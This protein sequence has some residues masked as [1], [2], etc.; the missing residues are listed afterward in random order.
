MV[1]QTVENLPAIQD[2]LV[3]SLGWENPLEKYPHSSIIAW[4][5]PQTEEPGGPR[6]MGLK[7]LNMTE[8]LI[9]P[10]NFSWTICFGGLAP[11]KPSARTESLEKC[12][13]ILPEHC[14]PRQS[15]P[16]NWPSHLQ[17]KSQWAGSKHPA[18]ASQLVRT[19]LYPHLTP[20]RSQGQ[21]QL[22]HSGVNSECPPSPQV[23]CQ[24]NSCL[25]M[26]CFPFP[27]Q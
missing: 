7:Q 27:P 10:R 22:L 24:T 6:S 25:T 11:L 23:N 19:L 1:A 14:L 5:I 16:S 13:L 17:R 2:T 26:R 21:S 3:P 15:I 18:W 20:L 8:Q 4:R 12:F 9:S